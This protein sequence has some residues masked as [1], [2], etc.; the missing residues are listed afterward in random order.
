MYNSRSNLFNRKSKLQDEVK[1][2]LRTSL[3]VKKIDLV[4][5]F[6]LAQMKKHDQSVLDLKNSTL[7]GTPE[8]IGQ[9]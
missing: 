7:I 4:D 6:L 2:P 8:H 5:P 3:S 1:I 9:T